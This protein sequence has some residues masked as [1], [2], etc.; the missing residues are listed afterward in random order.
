[1]ISCDANIMLPA[2]N[3]RSPFQA[4]AEAFLREHASDAEFAICELVLM[5]L[6]VLLRNPAVVASP[7]SASPAA[8]IIR[9]YRGNPRWRVI[10]YPGGLMEEVWRRAGQPETARRSIFDARLALTLR[11]H[12]V[13]RF[14]TGNVKH[15]GDYGFERVWNPLSEESGEPATG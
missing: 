13:T 5:E 2:S 4:P 3:A 15:F 6:Y 11:H 8:E 7:L 10:D 9:G 14:A 12:G 1:L